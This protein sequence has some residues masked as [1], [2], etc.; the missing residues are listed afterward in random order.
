MSSSAAGTDASSEVPPGGDLIA[1]EKLRREDAENDDDD[2][3]DDANP[4][5]APPSAPL[6]WRQLLSVAAAAER[7]VGASLCMRRE[8]EESMVFCNERKKE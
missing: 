1:A 3:S 7:S 6:C 5:V 8:D 4:F 2:E